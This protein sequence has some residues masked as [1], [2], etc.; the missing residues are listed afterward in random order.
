MEAHL[1]YRAQ[2]GSGGVAGSLGSKKTT[3]KTK[4]VHKPPPEPEPPK[5]TP[6]PKQKAQPRIDFVQRNIDAAADTK[7]R[8]HQPKPQPRQYGGNHLPGEIPHYLDT[9][10][11]LIKEEPAQQVQCPKGMRL[12]TNEEKTEALNDLR[13][14]KADIESRLGKMPL[15]IES[16]QLIRQKRIMEDQLDEITQS[17]E[18]LSK[19]YV[20]LPE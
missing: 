2:L 11:E 4:P 6:K 13:A 3:K 10:K 8:A 5:E 15:R 19:K 18:Q 12:M 7:S 1:R 17:I 20:F 14:E 9:R 16:P